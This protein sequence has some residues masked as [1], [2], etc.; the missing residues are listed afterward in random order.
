MGTL[1]VI[2]TGSRRSRSPAAT[3]PLT[4][5]SSC[6]CYTVSYHI[7][8]YNTI[9]HRITLYYIILTSYIILH[10]ICIILH[11][12][13]GSCVLLDRCPARRSSASRGGGPTTRKPY[14]IIRS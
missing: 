12:I 2:G 4:S 5:L 1:N 6:T 3:D 10:P 9:L 7:I 14:H 11:H 13:E 8:S